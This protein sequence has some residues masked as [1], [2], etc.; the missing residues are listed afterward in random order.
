MRS[1]L[2]IGYRTLGAF[3]NKFPSIEVARQ[4]NVEWII[5]AA[6]VF[7]S[8]LAPQLP[9]AKKFRF[10]FMSG[11]LTVTDQE[12]KN[13]CGLWKIRANS[14]YVVTYNSCMVLHICRARRK[15]DSLN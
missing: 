10:L 14:R 5:T 1:W 13:P 6:K 8:S 2:M 15:H 12:F 4:V 11:I 3:A 9:E 7:A